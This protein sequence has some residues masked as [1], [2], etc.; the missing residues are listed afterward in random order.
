[1]RRALNERQADGQ[2]CVDCDRDDRPM[3]PV[4]AVNEVQVF[5]CCAC[6]YCSGSGLVALGSGWDDAPCISCGGS[7]RRERRGRQVSAQ[8]K[9]RKSR[10]E[11]EPKPRHLCMT[12]DCDEDTGSALRIYCARCAPVQPLS[13]IERKWRRDEA[14]GKGART[15]LDLDDCDRL[16]YVSDFERTSE[17]E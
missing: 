7:G 15:G 13:P 6:A 2:S 14:A 11:P 10:R 9:P 8:R 17:D 16:P 4:G 5:S 1:M 12:L 3:V